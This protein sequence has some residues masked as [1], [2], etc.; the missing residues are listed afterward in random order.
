MHVNYTTRLV[1]LK[2]K[3]NIVLLPK[4]R[5]IFHDIYSSVS[6]K[7]W[8]RSVSHEGIKSNNFFPGNIET[9]CTPYL[10]AHVT[11]VASY[12]HG[13]LVILLSHSRQFMP[14]N[15]KLGHDQPYYVQYKN[16]KCFFPAIYDLIHRHMS[17]RQFSCFQESFC[18]YP[19]L[20]SETS[21]KLTRIVLTVECQ[22]S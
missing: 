9:Y 12:S 13:F 14:S 22:T 4:Q 17:R 7:L 18:G 3:K 1:V 6:I 21:V 8:L 19:L 5:H 16:S 11:S 10:E 2:K 20:Y 15:F